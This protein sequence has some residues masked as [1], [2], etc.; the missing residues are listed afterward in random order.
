MENP[1]KMD[2]LG[3]PLFLETPKH[4]VFQDR[5]KIHD[6]LSGS[7]TIPKK[8]DIQSCRSKERNSIHFLPAG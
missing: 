6:L 7:I 2:D 4:K 3:V 1:I 5:L 8:P